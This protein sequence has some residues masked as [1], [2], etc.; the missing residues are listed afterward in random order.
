MHSRH[1]FTCFSHGKGCTWS[2]GTIAYT[3]SLFKFLSRAPLVQNPQ[4]CGLRNPFVLLAFPL[5]PSTTK[6][7]GEYI[8]RSYNIRCYII[9][10]IIPFKILINLTLVTSSPSRQRNFE[11]KYNQ[12]Q[13]KV[14]KGQFLWYELLQFKVLPPRR[15]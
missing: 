15:R 2:L 4:S 7:A 9:I 5:H 8:I 6:V 13:C 10:I 3:L 12:F 14:S 1:R 11:L